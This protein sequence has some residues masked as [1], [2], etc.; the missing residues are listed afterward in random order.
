MTIPFFCASHYRHFEPIQNSPKNADPASV[1]SDPA[2]LRIVR[3]CA[4]LFDVPIAMLTH[5]DS[6]K[7]W[8]KAAEGCDIKSV[9]RQ[10]SICAHTLTHGGMMVV[11]DL[12]QDPR[13][14]SFPFVIDGGLRFYAGIPL[15]LNEQAIGTLC[16]MDYKPRTWSA[17]SSA[18]LQDMSDWTIDILNYHQQIQLVS[19]QKQALE[20]GQQAQK[21]IL[22]CSKDPIFAKDL[23]GRYLFANQATLQ[24]MGVKEDD[25]LGQTDFSIYPDSVARAVHQND[26]FVINHN[27]TLTVEEKIRQND[28]EQTMIVTKSPL[29][30]AT[31]GQVVGLVG[32]G[33]DITE[34]KRIQH[35]LEQHQELLDITHRFAHIG[36]W[37]WDIENTT[38]RCNQQAAHLLGTTLD[39]IAQIKTLEA[40]LSLICDEDREKVREA[41]IQCLKGAELDVEYRLRSGDS[42][43]WALLRGNAIRN[44]EGHC[45]RLLGVV[46]DITHIKNVEAQVGYRQHQLITAIENIPDGFALYDETDHLILCNRR[47]HELYP[48]MSPVMQEGAYFQDILRYGLEQGQFPE[49]IGREQEWLDWRLAHHNQPYSCF[50]YQTTEQRWVQIANRRV[51][52]LGWVSVQTDISDLKQAQENADAANRSKSE[53]LSSMS[54][55]L[56]TPMNAILG[57][58]QLMES[59]RRD[60]LTEKQNRQIQQIIRAGKHLLSLINEVLDLARIESGRLSLSVEAVNFAE[61]QQEVI[62]LTQQSAEDRAITLIGAPEIQCKVF[63][64]RVRLKQILLNLINNAIKYHKPEGGFVRLHYEYRDHD[65]IRIYVTDNGLGMSEAQ[66]AKLF[67]PFQR[68]GRENSNIEGTG[69]GLTIT[70]KL[71]EA[72]GGSM[73]LSSVEHQGSSF[74]FEL[75]HTATMQENEAAS[76]E[77]AEIMLN[78]SLST[79]LYIEDN[80]QNVQLME[81]VLF[82]RENFQLIHA[83]TSEK[84]LHLALQHQPCLIMMDINLP[85]SDGFATLKS[86]KMHEDTAKI[87]V[88]AI[89]ADTSNHTIKRTKAAG[90]DAYL[91]KP[92]DLTELEKTLDHY[93]AQSH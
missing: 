57:F 66:Q 24:V 68:L 29:L 55:E 53:F 7:M 13:F 31:T 33:H 79:I 18:S 19:A 76:A 8:I 54:H 72:M 91:G 49:A 34:R 62:A 1:P 22:E 87:P 21:A 11:E 10:D 47:Y 41:I 36:T 40:L 71:V 5:A 25:A 20:I 73:G 67:Q 56:R 80:P 69:I 12:S 44:T 70:Q 59:S 78:A 51:E 83:N 27:Q 30:D 86:L 46:Q 84:G 16:L 17:E 61:A 39:H 92:I 89:S 14:Q 9:N 15:I 42:P 63:A 4:R 45:I 23:E 43:R 26:Q 77:D 74:W 82:E 35:A 37:E 65:R 52:G 2:F 3:T 48:K 88:I 6:E 60:P 75:Q 85:D 90:F 28:V 50:I 93:L 81:D 58:A 38:L 32:V 64:D